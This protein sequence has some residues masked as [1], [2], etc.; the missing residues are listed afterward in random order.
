MDES[1]LLAHIYAR[2]AGTV[3]EGV[4]V[5]PGDDCAVIESASGAPP[6]L[7]T[8][9]Q[10]IEGR[11]FEPDTLFDRIAHKAIARSVS[12]LAAMGGA[13]IGALCAAS[14]PASFTRDDE[15]FDHAHRAAGALACPLIGGDIARTTGPLTLSITAIGR[16]HAMRGPVLRSDARPGDDLYLTGRLGGSFESGRHLSFTPRLGEGTA[17]CDTLGHH[18]GAMID[19]SDGLGRD[20]GR[21]ALASSVRL[22]IETALVPMHEGVKDWRRAVADGEDYELLFTARAEVPRTVAGTTIVRIGRVVAGEGCIAIDPEGHHH[23][24]AHAGWDHTA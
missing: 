14:L 2:A 7:L 4:L 21:I 1:R 10:L 20:A 3:P 11:H 15:L 5:G 18:L 12:D 17:L 23:D 13:P 8:V 16:A 19:L 24:I 22:E 9:D 6:L